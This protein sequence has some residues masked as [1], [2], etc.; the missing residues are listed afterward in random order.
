MEV[1]PLGDPLLGLPML[2]VCWQRLGG[3]TKSR[4]GTKFRL[5]CTPKCIAL[6]YNHKLMWSLWGCFAPNC[7][8][9]SVSHLWRCNTPKTEIRFLFASFG[10]KPLAWTLGNTNTNTCVNEGNPELISPKNSEYVVWITLTNLVVCEKIF[11]KQLIFYLG[12]IQKFRNAYVQRN[13]IESAQK[14]HS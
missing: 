5:V 12:F 10:M 7:A 13:K 1:N 4:C 9:R 2:R 6:V 14:V 11:H 8:H 3:E